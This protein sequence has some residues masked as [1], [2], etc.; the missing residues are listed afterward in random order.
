VENRL[1]TGIDSI[2]KITVHFGFGYLFKVRLFN[3]RWTDVV[4]HMLTKMPP[5]QVRKAL[6]QE[7][8]QKGVEWEVITY[9][10]DQC[11]SRIE[12]E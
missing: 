11:Y 4:V 10:H 7:L 2:D 6:G 8:S 12:K 5:D 1:V 3:G 9:K